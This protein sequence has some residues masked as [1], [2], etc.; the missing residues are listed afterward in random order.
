MMKKNK[1]LFTIIAIVA[2]LCLICG[3]IAFGIDASE[4]TNAK[5]VEQY[6]NEY[7]GNSDVYSKILAMT[8]C[9]ALQHE[10]D[11]AEANLQAPG[12]QQRQWGMGYMNASDSRMKDIGCYK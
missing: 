11:Q 5:T 6:M 8:D 1:T 10:F 7:G 9:A 2:S 4:R 12:T 3:A